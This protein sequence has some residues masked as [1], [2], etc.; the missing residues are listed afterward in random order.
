LKMNRLRKKDPEKKPPP[1]QAVKQGK[2]ASFLIG[3]L[4]GSFL[5][6]K[7]GSRHIPYAMFV[8]ILGILYIANSYQAEKTIR[9]TYRIAEELKEYRSEYVSLKSELMFRSNQSEVAKIAA[10]RI[11]LRESKEPPFKLF[12][13][14]KENPEEN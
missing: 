9:R 10:Q 12:A 14:N 7:G 11:G 13:Q 6:R 8:A 5:T 4:D 3:I 1:S 2:I